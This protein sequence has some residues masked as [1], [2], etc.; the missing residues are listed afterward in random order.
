[1]NSSYKTEQEYK[2]NLNLQEQM[3]RETLEILIS[4]GLKEKE[5]VELGFYFYSN[6]RLKLEKLGKD[7][8][9]KGYEI[10][11]IEAASLSGE[12]VLDGY[13]TG[14]M[15]NLETLNRWTTAMCTLGF[16]HDCEFSGWEVET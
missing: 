11:E 6:D 2:Q 14:L 3:N 13:A 1:M 16:A 8:S 5:H 15:L 12:F 7:L 9:A 4:Q 10:S